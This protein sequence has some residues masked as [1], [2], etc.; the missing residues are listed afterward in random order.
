MPVRDIVS[1]LITDTRLLNNKASFSGKRRRKKQ[2]KNGLNGKKGCGRKTLKE[3]SDGS[4]DRG[5]D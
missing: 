3:E 2:K 1:R 4:N 5:L